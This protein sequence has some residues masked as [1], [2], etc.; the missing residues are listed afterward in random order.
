MRVLL[1]HDYG[2]LGGGAERITV[3][4]RDG[5]RAR[6][7]EA[8]L[9]AS[10]ASDLDIAN[11]ADVTCF[12]T[13]G[14][15]RRLLQVWNPSAVRRLRTELR[16]FRPDVVHVRMFLT[17][18]SPAILPELRSVPSLLHVGNHQTVC[19]LNSR[20]L[21]DGSTCRERAG[22]PCRTHGCVSTLGLWRTR[23]QLAGV[24]RHL[25]VF[26]MVVANSHAL[27]RT[28]AENG[29]PV[30]DVIHNGTRVV[31]PRPPLQD[32]PTVMYAG[33]LMPLKGVDDL[34][35]AMAIVAARQPEARL[36]IAGDGRERL[37]LE[38]LSRDLGLAG[39][40]RFA[41]H[42]PRPALD[43]LLARGWVQCV[44]SR[45]LEPFANVVAEAMMRGTAI[46]ATATGG[47]PEQVREGATGFLVPAGDREAMA[48]RLLRLLGDRHL[49]ERMGAAGRDVARDAFS[50]DRMLDR[51]E[52]TYARAAHW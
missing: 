19:P 52:E 35:R 20:L 27:A 44:P 5:M 49:A 43:D 26:R 37:R 21:P 3:D 8:R 6:G 28:L 39:R 51:F 29:I 47:T 2:V 11:E 17:Q 10:T 15:P 7:Y 46:V 4:L 14:W 41:G 33:R 42:V 32:P 12:G 40:V 48:E 16:R 50:T 34:I 1:V 38:Q 23:V 45:Y 18:L 9:L 22:R 36:V 13:N 25:G 31:P 24:Q 30:T